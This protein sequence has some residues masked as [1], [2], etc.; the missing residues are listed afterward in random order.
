MCKRI[1]LGS[2]SIT[3][4]GNCLCSLFAQRVAHSRACISLWSCGTVS[5]HFYWRMVDTFIVIWVT[6]IVAM[7]PSIAT[8]CWPVCIMVDPKLI[9]SRLFCR[10][11][12]CSFSAGSFCKRLLTSFPLNYSGSRMVDHLWQSVARWSAGLHRWRKRCSRHRCFKVLKMKRDLSSGWTQSLACIFQ[13]L[14][15]Q[16]NAL[17]PPGHHYSGRNTQRR[18]RHGRDAFVVLFVLWN[19]G[20]LVWA[21]ARYDVMYYSMYVGLPYCTY[22]LPG[23]KVPAIRRIHD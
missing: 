22:A 10:N 2:Q 13:W 6:Q 3:S 7:Q 12:Y 18:C 17:G 21:G 11:I 20:A 15:K 14:K 8:P 9:R 5:C 23:T 19:Y 4:M 16:I 1:C